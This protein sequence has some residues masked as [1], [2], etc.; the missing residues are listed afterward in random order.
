MNDHRYW[1]HR[2]T[3][4]VDGDMTPADRLAFENHAEACSDCSAAV[5]DIRALVE[6][7][8]R[9][10]P[11]PPPRDL[12]PAIERGLSRPGVVG[13]PGET[14]VIALPT[15]QAPRKRERSFT[16]SGPQ[17]AAAA[18]VL[19]LLSTTVTLA[20]RPVAVAPGSQDPVPGA[21]RAASTESGGSDALLAEEVAALEE[22][23]QASRDRLDPNTVRIIE[24]NLAVIERAISESRQALLVDPESDFLRDH[25]DR[26][27]QRKREY[28]Q[29]ATEMVE[30]AG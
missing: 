2:L 13:S 16:L 27:F 29:E 17:L 3:E 24:K 22:G 15:A 10:G 20:L 6:E 18:A 12:W 11:T 1:T 28:L 19:M 4:Y 26:A 5:A 21:V 23:L 25:L 9:L 7:A 14:R 8:G 30:W